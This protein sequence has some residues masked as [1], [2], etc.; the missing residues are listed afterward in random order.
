MRRLL[1]AFGL[2]LFELACAGD[3]GPPRVVAPDATQLGFQWTA[4]ERAQPVAVRTLRSS[5]SASY[6]LV[7]LSEAEKPHVHDRSDLTTFVLTGRVRMHFQHRTVDVGP[8]D[9]VEIPRGVFHWAENTQ[10]EPSEAYVIFAP[11]FDGKDRR[12]V[13]PGEAR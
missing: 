4:E 11:A 10:S 9:V 13:E 7:L 1:A 3:R 2:S 8:G 5:D 12:L 6:H